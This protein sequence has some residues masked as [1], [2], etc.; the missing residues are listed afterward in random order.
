MY[1]SSGGCPPKFEKLTNDAIVMSLGVMWTDLDTAHFFT[2]IQCYKIECG[3]KDL[4][5]HE[6]GRV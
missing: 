5:V 4:G 1:C 2:E 6:A 3:L